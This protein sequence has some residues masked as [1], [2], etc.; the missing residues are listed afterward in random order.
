MTVML[1]MLPT[2]RDVGKLFNQNGFLYLNTR[3]TDKLYIIK[4]IQFN[5]LLK[6]FKPLNS[7]YFK[8]MIYTIISCH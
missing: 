8:A 3:I 6:R 2:A 5:R 1:Y 4:H 7:N